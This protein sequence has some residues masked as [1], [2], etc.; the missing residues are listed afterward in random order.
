[1]D[2]T[3]AGEKRTQEL[4]VVLTTLPDEAAAESLVQA[5][6]DER[7]IA[8]GNIL[9]GVLSIY[10]WENELAREREV[11]VVMKTATAAVE[12]LFGRIPEIHPYTIPELVGISVEAVSGAYGRWV[13]ESIKVGE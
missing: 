8:C 5:L 4:S 2:E 1:M 9:P 12:R 6:L 11:L 10:R 13:T 7:L 3:T